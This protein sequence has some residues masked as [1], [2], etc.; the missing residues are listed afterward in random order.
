MFEKTILTPNELA[1]ADTN[2]ESM[3]PLLFNHYLKCQ[4]MN[5]LSIDWD[6]FGDWVETVR[7]EEAE[8]VT[9]E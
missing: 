8:R 6:E 5:D 7:K 4:M 3:S 2:F 1:E 9:D